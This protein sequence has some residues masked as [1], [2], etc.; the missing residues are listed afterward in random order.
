MTVDASMRSCSSADGGRLT[1]FG[2]RLRRHAICDGTLI[3]GEQQYSG[4]AAARL[5][6]EPLG[7]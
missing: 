5:I 4:A 6:I 2:P 3:T 7:T 1:R